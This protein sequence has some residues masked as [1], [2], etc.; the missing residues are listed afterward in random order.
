MTRGDLDASGDAELLGALLSIFVE[1]LI[2][3]GSITVRDAKGQKPAR[4][5][6]YLTIL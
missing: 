1:D 5:A 4:R 2:L 3:E 6:S